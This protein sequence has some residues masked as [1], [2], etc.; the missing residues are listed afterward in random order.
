MIGSTKHL[1]AMSNINERIQS[2][3]DAKQKL[4][5]FNEIISEINYA[6]RIK[7]DYNKAEDKHKYH[8]KVSVF[9]RLFR[10]FGIKKYQTSSGGHLMD[11][12]QLDYDIEMMNE[13]LGVVKKYKALHEQKIEKI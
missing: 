5:Y 8:Y 2:L 7:S 10:L 3:R 6:K 11:Y 9:V 1:K 12:V 4:D 13:I